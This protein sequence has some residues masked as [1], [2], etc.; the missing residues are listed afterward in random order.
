[1]LPVTVL[2]I[3]WQMTALQRAGQLPPDLLPLV[4]LEE[5]QNVTIDG[6]GG[7]RGVERGQHEMAHISFGA[8][9]GR[10]AGGVAHLYRP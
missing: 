6:L 8:H 9:G 4:R 1:M 2:T 7:V 3:R 10:E 5:I